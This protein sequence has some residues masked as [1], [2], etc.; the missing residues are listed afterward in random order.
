MPPIA[1]DPHG[2]SRMTV[3][4]QIEVSAET[5]EKLK[6]AVGTGGAREL[7]RQIAGFASNTTAEPG[8]PGFDELVLSFVDAILD[9]DETMSVDSKKIAVP[10]KLRTHVHPVAAQQQ[11]PASGPQAQHHEFKFE[12]HLALKPYTDPAAFDL[13][14]IFVRSQCNLII[15]GGTG[16][17]KSFLIERLLSKIEINPNANLFIDPRVGSIPVMAKATNYNRGSLADAMDRVSAPLIVDELFIPRMMAEF[18]RTVTHHRDGYIASIHST[19][20]NEMLSAFGAN[21]LA[22]SSTHADPDLIVHTLRTQSGAQ[23]ITHI[24]EATFG[25]SREPGLRE[26]YRLEL[27]MTGGKRRGSKLCQINP[28]SHSLRSKVERHGL[29]GELSKYLS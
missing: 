13:I 27:P 15:S 16:S 7:A 12:D 3:K 17:G 14:G 1:Q 23:V 19:S 11:A 22:H 4:Y 2:T 9:T 20:L 21:P 5:H 26:L 24:S 8:P 10:A 6:L 18:L 25:L 29:E 28:P